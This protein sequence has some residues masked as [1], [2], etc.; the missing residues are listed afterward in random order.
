VL[1]PDVPA[2][3]LLGGTATGY[4]VDQILWHI[5]GIGDGYVFA[6]V[7]TTFG[8]ECT[9]SPLVGSIPPG[10]QVLFSFTP[11]DKTRPLTPSSGIAVNLGDRAFDRLPGYP[12]F[13]I[14]QAIDDTFAYGAEASHS[15]APQMGKAQTP[16]ASA[17]GVL[18][19]GHGGDVVLRGRDAS[20]G[21]VGGAGQV[22]FVVGTGT[23][24][25]RADLMVVLGH[26]TAFAL[27]DLLL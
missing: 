16:I 14:A 26:L 25:L 10:G 22:R 20:S 23:V 7:T 2:V 3:V 5:T 21:L 12:G 24:T 13:R 19:F 1:T 9:T 4:R 8:G 18:L 6:D 15:L 17:T 27:S 11:E